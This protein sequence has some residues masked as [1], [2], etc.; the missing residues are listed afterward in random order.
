M[1]TPQKV[2]GRPD[3]T[4]SLSRSVPY[5]TV[6]VS[7]GEFERLFRAS[8]GSTALSFAAPAW[9][10]LCESVNPEEWLSRGLA[11]TAQDPPR[12]CSMSTT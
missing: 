4:D 12:A 11:I 7:V 5:L 8:A 6:M 2:G 3:V 9:L 10:N 1:R